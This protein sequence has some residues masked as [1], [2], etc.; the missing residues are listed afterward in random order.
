M[1]SETKEKEITSSRVDTKRLKSTLDLTTKSAYEP[2][3]LEPNIRE[4]WESSDF[5]KP[6]NQGTSY[7]I[8]QPPPNVTGSLHMGHGFQTAIMDSLIRYNRMK[9]NN[10]LWQ[11][12]ID[13]AGIATQMVVENQLKL[14]GKKRTDMS[15]EEFLKTVWEWKEKSGGRIVH[16]FHRM[17]ASADWSRLRFT[18]DKGLSDAVQ[19]VFIDLY[20]EKLIYRGKKLVNWDPVLQTAV[21]DLEVNNEEEKGSMWYLRYPILDSDDVLIVATTRPETMLGD[22]AVAVHPTDARFSRFIGKKILLPLVN[23]E[24]PIVAD[25][26]VDPEFGTG[27]VKVTPAHDFNDFEVGKRHNLPS[28]NILTSEARLNANAPAQY[29]GLTCLEARKKIIEDLKQ[30]GV[31]EKIEDHT[32]K[33]PRGERTNA[34]IEPYLTDQWFVDTSPLAGPAIQ[35]VEEGKIKF[36][37]E[38]WSKVYFEWMHKIEDWCISRQLWWGHRI[39]AWYDEEGRVFV[40][41]DE[42]DIREKYALSSDVHLKQ[43]EDVLDTWFSSALWPFSTLD[44]PEQTPELKTFYPTDVLVTGHDIIFFWVA[45]MIMFGMKFADNVPFKEVLITGLIYDKE[46]KKMSKSKGN[47]LDP[48]DL[49]DGIDLETLVKK[50]TEGLMQ[51]RMAESIER[52]TRQEFPQ[53]IPAYGTDALRFAYLLLSSPGNNINFNTQVIESARNFCNKIWNASKYVLQK[54]E[55]L[56]ISTILNDKE[57]NYKELSVVDRWMLSR[58]QRLVSETEESY[59]LYRFDVLAKSLYDF[60]WHDFCDWYLEFSKPLLQE[61]SENGKQ[62]HAAVLVSTLETLLRLLH[63]LMPFITEGLWQSVK[64]LKGITEDTIMLQ[65]YPTSNPAL[66]DE[67]AE[68]EIEWVK[69]VVSSI[70]KIRGGTSVQANKQIPVLLKHGTEF[71]QHCFDRHGLVVRTLAKLSSVSWLSSR[72]AVPPSMT[73]VIGTLEIYIPMGELVNKESEIK[74]LSKEITKQEAFLTDARRKLLDFEKSEKV[75]QELK[76]KQMGRVA[77]LEHSLRKLKDQLLPIKVLGVSGNIDVGQ[78]TLDEVALS[79]QEMGYTE[80]SLAEL[81]FVQIRELTREYFAN[82]LQ[83]SFSSTVMSVEKETSPSL[84]FVYS[85]KPSQSEPKK[86]VEAHVA[87]LGI[88]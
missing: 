35:A 1:F 62:N 27:C 73:S 38:K 45:R 14:Q 46:G 5:F 7:C 48:I 16:Q 82:K 51:Q 17:G 2:K 71:D 15:R 77:E 69:N 22:T 64:Q 12:G 26:M 53:G 63:P 75:P 21:S 36:V 19:K 81:T 68:N 50:R 58:L 72:D 11:P 3:E 65:A 74:K 83:G 86:P 88:Q 42:D 78:V 57:I 49:V 28:I 85:G 20:N 40:G 41:R 55:Q 76:N 33:I 80:Q 18:L 44:W 66:I 25:E 8:M 9:G 13:H 84:T 37:P 34:I 6:T 60:A 31:L 61:A 52:S 43:D 56:K 70:R 10:T 54:M 29:Q 87:K 4:F 32:L 47:V 23:R 59:R 24:I 39:P 30:Q 67:A 79:L